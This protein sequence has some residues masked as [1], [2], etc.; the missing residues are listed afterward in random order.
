[1]KLKKF[2]FPKRRRRK[3]NAETD[4][5]VSLKCLLLGPN[6][7]AKDAFL[8]DLNTVDGSHTLGKN[9]G[10]LK[11]ENS[12]CVFWKVDP[13]CEKNK[14][15]IKQYL[16]FHNPDI[17][18][19]FIDLDGDDQTGLE[20]MIQ[21]V[22]ALMEVV[23]EDQ[24]FCIVIDKQYIDLIMDLRLDQDLLKENIMRII[25]LKIDFHFEI[26]FSSVEE[27]RHILYNLTSAAVSTITTEGEVSDEE[28]GEDALAW[29]EFCDIGGCEEYFL[30]P[31]PVRKHQLVRNDDFKEDYDVEEKDDG[32]WLGKPG[33]N[34]VE[35]F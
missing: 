2:K 26:C 10:I 13:K 31:L 6:I 7:A 29:D 19:Y 22:D 4:A 21:K 3:K 30:A 11:I 1:M 24:N 17:I 34:V 9:E 27:V 12:E 15:C 16:D 33:Q 20:L 35:S 18:L 32:S 23:Q 28:T 8:Y 14:S 25:N 5:T